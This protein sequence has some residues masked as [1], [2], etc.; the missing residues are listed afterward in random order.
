MYHNTN[1]NINLF[2]RRLCKILGYI[3]H[4]PI[5]GNKC[6]W[7]CIEKWILH[8]C[9]G[10]CKW[11]KPMW[12]SVSLYQ[13][14]KVELPCYLAIKLLSVFPKDPTI[15]TLVTHVVCDFIHDGYEMK[16]TFNWWI[17]NENVVCIHKGIVFRC[18]ENVIFI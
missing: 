4:F 5:T 7:G 12:I 13:K 16:T 1:R 9:W 11:V 10:D 2:P 8:H 6:W 15:E 18:N 3:G 14:L 17:D